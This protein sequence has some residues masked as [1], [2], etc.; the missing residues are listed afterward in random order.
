MVLWGSRNLGM[1]ET[2]ENFKRKMSPFL[3]QK[4]NFYP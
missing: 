4:K 1:R 2:Q 3:I